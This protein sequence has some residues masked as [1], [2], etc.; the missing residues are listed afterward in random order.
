MPAPAKRLLNLILRAA[1]LVSKF[2]LIFVLAKF[3]EPAEVGLY[4]LLAATVLYVLMALGFDFYTFSTRELIVTDR[5]NWAGM[6]RD[7]GVFYGITYTALFPLCLLLFWLGLLPWHLA[8]WFFPLLALEHLAQELN[9]LLVAISEPLWASAVLFVRSGA[10]AVVATLWMWLDPGQRSLAFVLAAWTT[11]VFAACGLGVWRMRN[12][13]SAS[14]RRAIDWQWIR[15][16]IRIAFPFVLATLSLRALYT[17]DRYWIEA[18]GGLEVLAAYVLFVGIAN[19]IMSFLDAAVFTF[20]YPAL[21]ATA[22]KGDQTAFDGQMR[23]LGQHT[24]A[25]TAGLSVAAILCAGPVIDW[26]DRPSYSQHFTLL[27]WTVLAA[28]LFGLSMVPHYGLYARRKDRPIILSHLA[29][30]PLFCI[31]TLALG[32][33]LGIAAVPAAMASAFLFLLLAKLGAFKR[34]GPLAVPL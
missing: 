2:A 5:R 25:V 29:S 13:D 34:C 8:V 21:I 12:L 32:P 7:Q 27:Y 14:L 31:A 22:G 3:L 23:R 9:R 17:V 4:G 19:A 33:L 11:G 26:L 18:L 24:L 10:W 6:L 16:G 15:Q 1:T 20:A 28:A 30:L